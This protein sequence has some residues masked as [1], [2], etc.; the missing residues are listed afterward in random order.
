MILGKRDKLGNYHEMESWANSIHEQLHEETI[1][2]YTKV[3]KAVLWM[4]AFSV[5]LLTIAKIHSNFKANI[6]ES[7]IFFYYFKA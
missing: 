5:L 4:G 1:I 7:L 2:N 3:G 6:T